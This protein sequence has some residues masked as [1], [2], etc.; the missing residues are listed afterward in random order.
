[1][2]QSSRQDANWSWDVTLAVEVQQKH[3]NIRV[4]NIFYTYST[5]RNIHNENL[6]WQHKSDF[7]KT[8]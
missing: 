1:M 5:H 3:E 4:F 2:N 8:I 6:P 7:I